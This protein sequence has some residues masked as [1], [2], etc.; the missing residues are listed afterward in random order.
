MT[1]SNEKRSRADRFAVTISPDF[2]VALS[3]ETN[4]WYEAPKEVESGLAWGR[5]KARLL[6]WVRLHIARQ[7][8]PRERQCLELHFFK[9][10]SIADIA[11]QTN[12]DIT[13]VH[14]AVRRS[15]RKLRKMAGSARFRGSARPP[16]NPPPEREDETR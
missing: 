5:R 6:R 8:T 10:V 1:N 16:L 2:F 11:A 9:G 13:S 4:P 12:S 7:L 3:E 15:V 14:R